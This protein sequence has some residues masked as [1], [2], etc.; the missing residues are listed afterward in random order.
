MTRLPTAGRLPA[1]STWTAAVAALSSLPAGSL[2]VPWICAGLMPAGL[3]ALLRSWR[4]S[5][6][7]QAALCAAVQAGL[8]WSAHALSGPLDRPAALA[9]TLLPPL[10]YVT[11]RGRA[12]ELA[13]GLFLSFCLLLVGA[14]LGGRSLPHLVVFVFAAAVALRCE[15]RLSVLRHCQRTSPAS[16][17]APVLGPAVALA[18]LC[19]LCAAAADRALTLLPSPSIEGIRPTVVVP[20]PDAPRRTGLSD[21]FA[22]GGGQPSGQRGDV[23][24]KVAPSAGQRVPERLY[25]RTGFFQVAD[26]E[27]WRIGP[28]EITVLRGAG[29][30]LELQPP[31]PGPELQQ[32]QVT[33]EPA[34]A[35]LMF[36]PPDACTL[37]GIGELRADRSRS[38]YRRT[39]AGTPSTYGV[40]WQDLDAVIPTLDV[41]TTWT[42]L[43]ALPRGLDQAALRP[44]LEEWQPRPGAS[45]WELC[46]AIGKGLA[47]RCRYALL[48]P[49][50]PHGNTLL[51]FLNGNRTGYCM[52]FASAA[53]ILLRMASVPCRIGTGLHGGV[54]D[55]ELRGA[56][57]YSSNHAHAW[58]EIPVAGAGW[59][60]F[61]PTPAANRGQTPAPA[62]LV[63]GEDAADEASALGS[64]LDRARELATSPWPALAV[65]LAL[66]AVPTLRRGG[67][68]PRAPELPRELKPARAL[69]D[70]LL[71]ALR[72]RGFPRLPGHT[73]EQYLA[74][75]RTSSAGPEPVATAFAAYQEVRFGGSPFDA[76]REQ[77]LQAGLAAAR[78]LS[79]SIAPTH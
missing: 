24:V 28:R 64:L 39:A 32:L 54:A 7:P 11:V 15:A 36:V 25:L 2:P 69:L 21:N 10:G 78:E 72:E 41:D 26:V 49:Q 55:P 63:A 42:A 12:G 45:V 16:T 23:L 71:S 33:C 14:I 27:E 3:L 77:H 53:A 6:L 1:L 19:G 43:T 30:R 60:V 79:P 48:Q 75:L 18:L 4:G 37:L 22:L 59:V 76:T 68:R 47:Q 8:A 61:D 56:R 52:H 73:L 70:R 66:V 31:L 40:L 13:L 67:R 62:V 17:R 9:A 51:N 58:V 44:L 35:D 34:T 20:R 38:W 5:M 65:L 74:S 46:D 57:R 50:G 29:E